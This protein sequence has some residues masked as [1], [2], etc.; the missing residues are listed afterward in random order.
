MWILPKLKNRCEIVGK[1]V[2]QEWWNQCCFMINYKDSAQRDQQLMNKYLSLGR[3]ERDSVEDEAA[4]GQ[5]SI[6]VCNEKINLVH[7]F[8]EGYKGPSTDNMVNIVWISLSL[9]YAIFT[10]LL[11]LLALGVPKLWYSD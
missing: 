9:A 1:A 2:A 11:K 7:T 8:C 6:L 10:G 5:Q 4:S 3:D